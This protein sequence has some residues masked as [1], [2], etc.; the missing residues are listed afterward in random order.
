[1]KYADLVYAAPGDAPA[2][3]PSTFPLKGF[4][5]IPVLGATATIADVIAAYASLV[6]RVSRGSNARQISGVAPVGINDDIA[7]PGP[8]WIRS[9]GFNAL[10][11]QGGQVGVTYRVFWAEDCYEVMDPGTSPMLPGFV[12]AG[13]AAAAPI[14]G[15]TSQ[16]ANS[17]ANI[18]AAAGDGQLL[19]SGVKGCYAVASAQAA[20]TILGPGSIVWWRYSSYLGR[21]AETTVQDALSGG[22]RD[23]ATAEQLMNGAPNDRIYAEARSV[24]VSAG[25][26]LGVLIVFY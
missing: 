12:G 20:A 15:T 19:P 4:R 5:V 9:P 10:N 7:V 2:G 11:L 16:L 22:R 18:P 6:V 17:V 3:M 13:A 26:N 21:W 25:A 24:T 8:D 14:A 23:C 1:M